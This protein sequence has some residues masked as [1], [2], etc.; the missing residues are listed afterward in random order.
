MCEV[1]EML[2]AISGKSVSNHFL[3][4]GFLAT[5]VGATVQADGD[6]EKEVAKRIQA[7][8]SAWWRI[9]KLVDEK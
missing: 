7:G 2:A 3:A 1:T 6:S 4:P 5:I 8:W 9:T